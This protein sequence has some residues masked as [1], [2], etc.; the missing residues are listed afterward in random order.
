M[1]LALKYTGASIRDAGIRVR[2]FKDHTM[3]KV[4]DTGSYIPA[5]GD[6][7]ET[8]RP[9]QIRLLRSAAASAV[10]A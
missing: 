9:V 6:A 10:S 2:V 7:V 1:N 5:A 4:T 8:G 3:E